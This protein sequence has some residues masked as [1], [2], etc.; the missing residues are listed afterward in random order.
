[1]SALI[2]VWRRLGSPAAV[3][4]PVFWVALLM[5]VFLVFTGSLD[6]GLQLW[7]QLVLLAST[8]VAVM[9]FLGL[10]RV[11]VLRHAAQHPRP[12]VTLMCFVG[13]GLSRGVMAAAIHT[14][15]LGPETTRLGTRLVAG[16]IAVVVFLVPTAIIV[17]SWRDYR[18]RRS[19]LAIRQ[20]QLAETADR[21]VADIAERDRAVVD[22]VRAELDSV[23]SG[24][25]PRTQLREW[26]REVIRPLSHQL[27][28]EIEV[29]APRV[30]APERV[31]ASVVVDRATSGAPL[32]RVPTAV[33]AVVIAFIAIALAF[34]WWLTL[35]YSALVLA[36]GAA[37]LW[38]ANRL[39]LRI[40]HWAVALRALVMVVA[41]ALIGVAVGQLA[42]LFLPDRDL[43]FSIMRGN[44]I[45]FVAFG[46]GFAL[47]R[48]VSQELR[49]TLEELQ[50]ADARLTWQVARL[51]LVQWA[52]GARFARALHGPV[53]GTIA[54]AIEQL[55]ERP[56]DQSH[57]LGSLRT[58]LLQTLD[59]DDIAAT[60]IEGVDRL[61][62]SWEGVCEVEAT[63]RSACAQRLDGDPA[64]REMALE[65]VTEAV[66]NA[67]RHG[68]ATQVSATMTCDGDRTTLIV[69][70]NGQ[71]GDAGAPGLGTRVLE[72]CAL[73]WSRDSVPDGSALRAVLPIAST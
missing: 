61:R 3:S 8:Q 35:S 66:S 46:V 41:L 55:R 69:Q 25:D 73:E 37:L 38:L 11:T 50:L 28:S 54:V 27:A 39:M 9:G 22:R 72:S 29:G 14:W 59:G 53:Q 33:A 23:L 30:V 17:A 26:S 68:G 65:I 24:G 70:D 5:N 4:W 49:Q 21:L 6:I 63:T 60:W 20:A 52:Q 32:L 62:R 15:F 19:Q 43:T 10:C 34:G 44:A 67:V 18:D 36:S 13:A 48:A 16:I 64:C 57:I 2:Q 31:R 71:G 1:M 58:S 12:V 42:H 7:Q 45:L 56:Q 47:V 51:R 40:S